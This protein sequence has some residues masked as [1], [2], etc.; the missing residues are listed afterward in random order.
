MTADVDA[1]ELGE[2]GVGDDLQRLTRRIRQEVEM[3]QGRAGKRLW[4]S[5]GKSL[6]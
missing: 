1:L 5:M 3:E 2:A 4:I 6:A